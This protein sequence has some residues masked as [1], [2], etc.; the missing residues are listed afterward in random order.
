[1]GSGKFFHD[2]IPVESADAG[3]F[4]TAE[5]RQ[6]LVV[7]GNIINMGHPGIDSPG[8]VQAPFHVFGK[9]RT[10]QPMVGVIGQLQG[11]GFIIGDG[12][13]NQRAEGFLPAQLMASLHRAE[14]VL[15]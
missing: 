12:D 6:G 3:I 10:G 4:L 14:N 8:K 2:V 5:G 15:R 1:M 9:H 11:V 7:D 13:R